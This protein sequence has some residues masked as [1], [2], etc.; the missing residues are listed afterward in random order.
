VSVLADDG[1]VLTEKL[2]DLIC[3]GDEPFDPQV[4]CLLVRVSCRRLLVGRA[5]SSGI[6]KEK[7]ACNGRNR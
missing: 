7:T 1:T 4:L 2:E 6:G 5:G 3:L